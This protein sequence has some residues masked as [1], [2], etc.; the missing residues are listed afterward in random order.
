MTHIT[1]HIL[2]QNCPI[3]IADINAAGDIY[4]PNIGSLK[5]KTVACPNPHTI[6]GVDGGTT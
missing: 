2:L 4:G 1:R 5:E 6:T 3:T